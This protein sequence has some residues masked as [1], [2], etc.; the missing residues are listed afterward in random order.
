MQ[1]VDMMALYGIM[2]DCLG[3]PDPVSVGAAAVAGKP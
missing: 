2:R 1:V 3:D